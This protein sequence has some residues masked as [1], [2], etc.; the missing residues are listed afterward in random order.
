MYAEEVSFDLSSEVNSLDE[1]RL[2]ALGVKINK[3]AQD[4]FKL[5][6]RHYPNEQRVISF[7]VS[8]DFSFAINIQLSPKHCYFLINGVEFKEGAAREQI[9]KIEQII[10]EV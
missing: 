9:S 5:V 1:G 8:P 2:I 4:N 7:F 3:Y 10:R 6:H